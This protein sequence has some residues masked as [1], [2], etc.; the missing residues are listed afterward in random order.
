[1]VYFTLI[2]LALALQGASPGLPE[3]ADSAPAVDYHVHLMSPALVGDWKSLGVPFSRP[4]SVYTSGAVPLAAARWALFVP[5]GHLYANAE[6]RDALRLSPE[7][8]G[9]RVRRENDYVAAAAA[10]YPGRAAAACSVNPLRPYA[11]AELERC[12]TSLGVGVVKVHAASAGLDL[13][14]DDH[15]TTLTAVA[16]W[17]SARRVTLLLHLD[18]QMRGHAAADIT[19]FAEAVLEP[20][21]ALVAVVAHLGGSGGY[22]EWT[23]TVLGTLGRWLARHPDRRVYFDL[24]AV[25]LEAESEGIPPTTTAEAAAL[26]GD[27]RRVGLERMV[28]GSDYPVFDPARYALL[29]RRHLALTPAELDQ[30]FGN[31]VP[32]LPPDP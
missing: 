30:L 18:P 19:R 28:F 32:G 25:V 15:L 31:R 26:T 16:A 5:M 17:A 3:R 4:D 2:S 10:R 29:L 14:R 27:L 20:N 8:E 11:I 12:H 22:G 13:R 21:P 23:R 24:S 6:F 1:M 9:A 7:D